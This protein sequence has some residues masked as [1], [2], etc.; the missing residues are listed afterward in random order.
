[1]DRFIV[2]ILEGKCID[3]NQ[4][5]NLNLSYLC[6]DKLDNYIYAEELE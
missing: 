6:Q 2:L 5:R 4:I 3:G 1:M